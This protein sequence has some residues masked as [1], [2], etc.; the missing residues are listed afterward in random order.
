MNAAAERW[1]IFARQDLRIS[2]LALN[3]GIFNQVCF[4]A[5]QCA[6]KAIKGWLEAQGRVAPR[7]HRMAD[8]LPLLP[9]HLLGTFARRVLLLDAFYILTRYPDALPGLLADGL[10]AESDAH[11]AFAVARVLLDCI[12]DSLQDAPHV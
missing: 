12:T 4:H 5:Q 2:E 7:T 6:E 1:L 11:E 8:L 10:P 9:T 3:E